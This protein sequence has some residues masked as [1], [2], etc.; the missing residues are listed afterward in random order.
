M[1]KHDELLQRIDT[2]LGFAHPVK[3]RSVLRDLADE[4]KRKDAVIERLGDAKL[5]LPPIHVS[6][7]FGHQPDWVNEFDARILYARDNRYPKEDK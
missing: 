2:A 1:N 4:L 7:T 3:V 6:R 5:F